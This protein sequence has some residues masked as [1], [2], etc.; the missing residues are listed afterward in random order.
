MSTL[1]KVIK[2]DYAECKL[3]PFCPLDGGF[4]GW[5]HWTS[6]DCTNMSRRRHRMCNNPTPRLG[7][8]TCDGKNV[9]ISQCSPQ[10]CDGSC[11]ENSKFSECVSCQNTCAALGK[12]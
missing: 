11:P 7:G 12:V 10:E 3:Y 2:I 6:C 1:N 5:S 4:S 9:E 8:R